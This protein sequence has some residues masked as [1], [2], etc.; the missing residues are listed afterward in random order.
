M[1]I[2]T[3]NSHLEKS[4]PQ[5]TPIFKDRV[6]NFYVAKKDTFPYLERYFKEE[7]ENSFGILYS[8]QLKEPPFSKINPFILGIASFEHARRAKRSYHLLD[9]FTLH[10][11]ADL[12]YEWEDL[13]SALK[14]YKIS[15]PYTLQPI[16]LALS[17]ASIYFL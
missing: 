13:G 6:L 10:V 12:Y 16:E 17:E 14:F 7:R 15:K 4:F 3:N 8:E 11:L 2:T 1:L 5:G 9:T